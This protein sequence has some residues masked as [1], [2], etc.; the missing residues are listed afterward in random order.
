MSRLDW[1]GGHNVRALWRTAF[2][3]AGTLDRMTLRGWAA[4]VDYGIRTV[5]D[6]RNPDE[7]APDHSRAPD[8]ITRVRLPLDQ[9]HDREFWDR[10]ESGPAFG[11]PLYYGPHLERFPEANARVLRAIAHA[12]P[13]GVVFH[14]GA[15]RDRTGQIAML[16]LALLGASPEEIGAEYALSY[17]HN[18]DDEKLNAHLRSRGT[19]AEAEIARILATIDVRALVNDADVAALSARASR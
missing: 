12:A 14:C 2:V 18:P 15:G 6:L 19:T 8:E 9:K 7:Y 10:W 17:G 5:I 4:A 13:G 16:V 1:E 11:T 3:R